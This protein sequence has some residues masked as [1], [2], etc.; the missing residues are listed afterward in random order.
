MKTRNIFRKILY[1]N[2]R[3]IFKNTRK[4]FASNETKYNEETKDYPELIKSFFEFNIKT[5]K[6]PCF[7]V[8]SSQVE[9]LN[10]PFDF[11]LAIIVKFSFNYRN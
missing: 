1:S 7:E 3:N 10:Q 4:F 6:I 8:Y 11:Y 9:I 5:K 2:T